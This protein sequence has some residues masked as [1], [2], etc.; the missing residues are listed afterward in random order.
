ML[1]SQVE[2]AAKFKNL[3]LTWVLFWFWVPIALVKK[4]MIEKEWKEWME[5]L[6]IK[7]LVKHNN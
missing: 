3:L 1:R 7:N 6:E 5:S 4:K 2:D